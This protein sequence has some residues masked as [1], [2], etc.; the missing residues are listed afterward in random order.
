[1]YLLI[2]PLAG[3]RFPDLSRNSPT[4]TGYKPGTKVTLK[5]GT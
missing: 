2:P 5:P 1:M 4:F 3:L